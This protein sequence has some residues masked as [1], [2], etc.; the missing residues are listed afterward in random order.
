MKLP[1][2]IRLLKLVILRNVF[3]S[4]FKGQIV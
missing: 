3:P 1:S 4:E 2:Y